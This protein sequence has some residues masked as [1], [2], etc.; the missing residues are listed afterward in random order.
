MPQPRFAVLLLL[1]VASGAC[2][3]IYQVLW[4]R[5]LS[6]VLGVTVYAA[7]TVLAAFMTGL[8]LGSAAA[9]HVL[10][11]IRRPLLAFGL[12]E[13]L[14]GLAALA[15]PAALRAAVAVYEAVHRSA[16]DSGGLVAIGRV[17][18]SFLVLLVPTVLMGLTLPVLSASG[19]VAGE[20]LGSRIGWL[21]AAN[22]AG[23]VTGALLAGYYLIGGIGMS[24]TF[25]LAAGVNVL[26]GVTALLLGRTAES[27]RTI[28]GES[29]TATPAEA[30]PAP[31]WSARAP[32]GRIAPTA[33]TRAVRLVVIVSGAAAL[34][35]EIVWFRILLQ[36]LPATTYAFT[37]MLGTVLAGIAIGGA[38][39]ARW[40]ARH[41]DW[42]WLL[43]RLLLATAVAVVVSVL[44]LG[45]TYAAGWRTSGAVQ[46]S[47]AAIFPA[48][49]LM[50]AA[51]P[52]ALHL[53]R[54]AARR[55]A[56]GGVGIARQVGRLYAL[57]VAGAIAG[58]LAGG[59][60]LLPLA[61]SRGSLILLGSL[62]ALSAAVLLMSHPE[63]GRFWW[64]VALGVAIFAGAAAAVPDPFVAAIARRHG[65]DH[66]EIW[67][68]EGVQTAVS[69]HQRGNQRI[70]FLDGLHQA[71]DTP[72]M[73]Y[74][75]RMIGHVPMVLH[76]SPA[77]VLVVGLGGG[78]TAGAV[79][80]HTGARVLIVELSDSVR[81]AAR[82]FAH[83]NYDVLNQPHVT[84]RVD[85]GRNFL[86]LTSRRFDV[87]TADI[88]QPNHA[89]AG[90]LYSREYFAL[91]RRALRPGGLVLQWIGERPEAHYKALMRTFLSVFPN[92]TLWHQGQLLV[93][94]IEPLAVDPEAIARRLTDPKVR[95]AL[96]EVGF[97][98]LPALHAWYTAGPDAMRRF[99]G[100]GPLL[101]DDRP[102]LEYHR[103]LPGG[104]P[105]V[106]M[107]QLRG[108]VS[109]VLRRRL[110]SE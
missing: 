77:D 25:L 12:A 89:G 44:L 74:M 39:S 49:F 85:D 94:S 87:V 61:A 4:L 84:L 83:V 3:L 56:E 40:L 81:Q 107:S 58:A 1:F 66:R 21:Y 26:V 42:H 52:V 5:Q 10:G 101:T 57:N 65:A 102:L 90:L 38:V 43:V 45:W 110:T 86:R 78:V 50:G 79:S 33:V 18:S 19:I 13:I 8:A 106:D 96:E 73:V 105:S 103:S 100:E 41:R 93:G 22:T 109:E 92:A 69:V 82:F 71:N 30:A 98:G 9:G 47:F 76:P 32:D 2:G 35:L 7:S 80:Q 36:F 70:L 37:T 99:V 11:W 6:I 97:E 95:A 63:R 48:A 75:H 14:I 62:Y 108:D 60:L 27:P 55:G 88:I 34:A 17:I 53:G 28:P 91:M 20:R 104:A 24:R 64:R 16:D 29:D 67:R 31:T 23:A 46:A 72:G 51:F 15:T 54:L 68:D 59:F